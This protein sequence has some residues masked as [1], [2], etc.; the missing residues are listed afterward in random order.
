MPATR[1]ERR[2]IDRYIHNADVRWNALMSGLSVLIV[3]GTVPDLFKMFNSIIGPFHHTFAP[4]LLRSSLVGIRLL[5]II[6]G[7]YFS[8]NCRGFKI[9]TLSLCSILIT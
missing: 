2:S 3:L 6:A 4:T 8:Q 1:I 9:P 7:T 5:S